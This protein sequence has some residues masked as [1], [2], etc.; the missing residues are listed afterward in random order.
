MKISTTIILLVLTAGLAAWMLLR[1]SGSRDLG[2]HL[3]FDWSDR[4]ATTGEIGVDVDPGQ[5][6]GIDLKVS[7]GEFSLRRQP[8][9]AW[10]ISGGIKDRVDETIVKELLSYCTKAQI[11]DILDAGEIKDGKVSAASLGLDDAN[12]WRVT[13][14]KADGSPLATIRLGKTAPLDNVSYVQMP[15]QESRPDIY[16]VS[17]DL[18]PLLARPPDSFR[19][20]RI[21]RYPSEVLVKMVVRKGEGEVEFSRTFQQAAGPS[22]TDTGSG[23]PVVEVEPTPWVI[24]RPL[25][26]APADQGAVNDFTAMICGAKVQAWLPYSETDN[27]GEKPVVEVTLVPAG[28]TPK[29]VTLA[30]FKDPSDPAPLPPNVK[31]G[32]PEATDI[33]VDPRSMAICRD[34]QRKASFKVARQVMD[35]LCFA[36]SPNNFRSRLL[37]AVNPGTVST[38]RIEQVEGD[39]VEVVRV[40]KKWSW[41]PLSGGTFSEAAPEAV[42]RLIELLNETE[43][44][45][46]ASDSLSDPAAFGLDKPIVSITIAAGRHVGLNQLTPVDNRNSQTLR[47]G[48]DPKNGRYYANFTRD[49]FVFRIGPELPGGIPRSFVKWRSLALPGFSMHQVKSVK[50]TIDNNPPLEMTYNAISNEFTAMLAGKDVTAALNKS[51]VESLV[52]TAGAL[53]V[54]AW[55]E[56]DAATAL[57][58]LERPAVTVEIQYEVFDDKPGTSH[59]AAFQLSLAPMAAADAPYC[60]GR[61]AD[62]EIPEP[63]LMPQKVLNDLKTPLLT[64]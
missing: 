34:T 38:I 53:Q 61:L 30:F 46:W 6:A 60:F 43:I 20:P 58:A 63:F 57:K 54:E 28:A 23:R 59:V 21:S 11:K 37:A 3:L 15:G 32:T 52:M 36:E 47:I 42:E 40:E 27:A 64:K 44:I 2:G 14:L 24:S 16:F 35:D 31:P 48:L 12:A 25:P 45:D 18:R 4:L 5:V 62:K 49:P 56:K 33:P 8:D 39:S 22:K 50:Q 19:D 13:W 41:R 51:A 7:S 55:Q 1:G 9:G 10:D 17:P 29:N 26:N